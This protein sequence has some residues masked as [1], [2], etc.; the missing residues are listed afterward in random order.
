MKKSKQKDIRESC[1]CHSMFALNPFIE[2]LSG[3]FGLFPGIPLVLSGIM[4][5]PFC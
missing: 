1:L 2:H 4:E 3:H 5:Y